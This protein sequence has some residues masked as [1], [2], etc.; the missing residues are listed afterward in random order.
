MEG[1]VADSK[2]VR[3]EQLREIFL[4]PYKSPTKNNSLSVTKNYNSPVN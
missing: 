1:N 2:T 3:C 4:F